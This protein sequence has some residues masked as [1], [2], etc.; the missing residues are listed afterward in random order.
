MR[1]RL[2]SFFLIL[3]LLSFMAFA[4]EDPFAELDF[5][6]ANENMNTAATSSVNDVNT[7][8]TET[9][10]SDDILALIESESK[11][12]SEQM[13]FPEESSTLYDSTSDIDTLLSKTGSSTSDTT[14]VLE[15][16]KTSTTSDIDSLFAETGISTTE[17]AQTIQSEKDTQPAEKK[18][19]AKKWIVRNLTSLPETGFIYTKDGKLGMF[20]NLKDHLVYNINTSSS[21]K[22]FDARNIKDNCANTAWIDNGKNEGIG[23]NITFTFEEITFAPVYE[24]KYRAIEVNEIKILNGF[25][26]DE[27]TWQKYNRVKKL[28]LLLNNQ[29]KYHINLRD[30]KNWQSIKLPVPITIKSGDKIKLEIVDIYPEIRNARI[31]NTAISE[32]YLIGGPAGPQVENKYIASHLLAE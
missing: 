29:L 6:F 27:D 18:Q 30:S 4:E 17:T 16:S 12:Q 7:G 5:G 25:C 32:I 2:L 24:K 19:D 9:S 31:T 14:S 10:S 28:K 13:L 11:Q 3:F 22:D 8:Q 26:K 15:S 23:E 21:K 20:R 1:N